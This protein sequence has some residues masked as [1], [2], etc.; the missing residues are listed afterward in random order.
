MALGG[1]PRSHSGRMTPRGCDISCKLAP[2]DSRSCGLTKKSQGVDLTK[3]RKIVCGMAAVA[4]RR[5][6]L[7]AHARQVARTTQGADWRAAR[8]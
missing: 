6:S 3:G 1:A 4:L 5:S 8:Q 7:E 2:G